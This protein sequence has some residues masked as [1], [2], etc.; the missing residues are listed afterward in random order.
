MPTA[1]P[2]FDAALLADWLAGRGWSRATLERLSGDVSAR[3]YLRAE[4][5]GESGIVVFYPPSVR[6]DC[7]RFLRSTALLEEAGV[8]VPRVLGADCERG[9][10]LVEDLGPATLHDLARLPEDLLPWFESALGTARRIAA[11]PREPVALLNP[12]LD[13]ALLRRE[14]EQTWEA[15][16]VP[17]GLAGPPPTA[18]AL[19]AAFDTLCERLGEGDRVPCHRDFMARNL[20]PLASPTRVGVLDHQGLRLGPPLYD[21]ASLLNDSF[22]PPPAVEGTLLAAW[23]LHPDERLAYR[24]AAV[25]RTLK[26]VGTFARFAR[27]GE[28]R[29]L[30]LVP[31]TLARALRHW[32]AVPECARLVGKVDRLWGPVARRERSL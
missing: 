11:L 19:A 23:G 32:G 15:F 8:R 31:P 9:L 30:P 21:L 26:A 12:P 29:H 13:G 1:L 24:R 4:R 3:V 17:R 6:G 20:M 28:P 5:G 27:R 2:S 10:M 22:F 16:L 14:L 7:A 18:S 25:Q